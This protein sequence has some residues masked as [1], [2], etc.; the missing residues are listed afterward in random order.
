MKTKTKKPKQVN[1]KNI[2][3]LSISK[4][5]KEELDRVAKERTLSTSALI[6]Q[7]IQ[8]CIIEKAKIVERDG[9]KTIPIVIRVPSELKGNE[10]EL[11]KWL[12]P[13]INGIAKVL[14]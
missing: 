4:P 3:S 6:K 9:D 10:Q 2:M 14:S 8:K 1:P 12:T 13:K 11:Q 5:M 7:L